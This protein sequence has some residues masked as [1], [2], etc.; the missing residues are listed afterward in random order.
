MTLG[1]SGKSATAAPPEEPGQ[2]ELARQL[3]MTRDQVRYAL[4]QTKGWFRVL[5]RAEVRDHVDGDED[6]GEEIRE[7]LVLLER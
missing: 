1:S 6:V 3:G 4:E 2:E 7:L 5:L